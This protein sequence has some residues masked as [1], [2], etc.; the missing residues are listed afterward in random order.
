[1][2]SVVL[3]VILLLYL[4]LLFFVA[5]FA[6]K[7]NKSRWIE[8]PYVYSFSIAVYCTAWTYYGSIGVASKSG[9]DYLPIYLGPIIIIPPSSAK[10]C[11]EKLRKCLLTLRNFYKRSIFESS[12]SGDF[13]Q[14]VIFLT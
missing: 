13:A 14:R 7:R 3:I 6:E 1:M 12:K 9:L 2:N 5:H 10:S 4:A 11:Y 8:N